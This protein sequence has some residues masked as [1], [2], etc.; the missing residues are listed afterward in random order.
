MDQTGHESL[1]TVHGYHDSQKELSAGNAP[2][3]PAIIRNQEPV[4]PCGFIAASPGVQDCCAPANRVSARQNARKLAL[5]CTTL[6]A[7]GG[8]C[9]QADFARTA[10]AA[11]Q[12]DLA[13]VKMEVVDRPPQERGMRRGLPEPF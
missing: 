5:L 6:L 11:P 3:A 2:L 13:Q 1:N 9:K 4:A 10:S 12:D 8:A 7:S